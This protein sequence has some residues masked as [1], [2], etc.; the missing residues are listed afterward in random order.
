MA[1]ALASLVLAI[2]GATLHSGRTATAFADSIELWQQQARLIRNLG[3]AE[4]MEARVEAQG[5]IRWR[6]GS[7]S[8]DPVSRSLEELGAQL[9]PRALAR[10][11][12]GAWR[13]R[14][15]GVYHVSPPDGSPGMEVT[16]D[17][18]KDLPIRLYLEQP[19]YSVQLRWTLRP[20]ESVLASM[21]QNPAGI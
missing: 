16:V 21:S 17:S 4:A 10:L 14:D 12:Q 18:G 19:G 2:L 13:R 6:G 9:E 11:L 15:T 20:A 8:T 7:L 5:L 3:R 1:A